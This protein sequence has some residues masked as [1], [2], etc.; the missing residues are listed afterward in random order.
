MGPRLRRL[1][2][3]VERRGFLAVLSA[4]IAPGVPT[5]MLNYVC[6]LS[7]VR[8]R[9][10]IAGTAIGGAPRIAAYAA[11]GASGGDFLSPPAL[12]G[13]GLIAV[14]GLALPVVALL[15]RLR[16]VAV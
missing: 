13:I 3:R 15:R 14:M 6:G 5:T 4:R 16:P 2:E 8:L 1:A 12:A 7:R 10:F 9:D 11:L